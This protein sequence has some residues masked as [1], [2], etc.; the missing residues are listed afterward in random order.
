MK[1]KRAPTW[2]I[3]WINIAVE[4]LGDLELA[5]NMN[6]NG[7]VNDFALKKARKRITYYFY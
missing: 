5:G 4:S 7:I 2:N 6:L 3:V 1:R